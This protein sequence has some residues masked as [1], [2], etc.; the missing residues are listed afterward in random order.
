MSNRRLF[1]RCVDSI[2]FIASCLRPNGF[3]ALWENNPWNPGAR[4]VMSRIPFDRD[5]IMLSAREARKLITAA[6]LQVI[7]TD[8]RFIFPRFLSALRPIEELAVRLP[9]GA[10]YQVLCQKPG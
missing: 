4:L 8:Y 3:F 1:Q 6:G 9:L 5:A 2:R 10:Q 7:R